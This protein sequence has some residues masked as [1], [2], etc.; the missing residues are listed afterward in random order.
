MS[1][2]INSSSAIYESAQVPKK[3][4]T[5][6]SWFLIAGVI[7][8]GVLFSLA[9]CLLMRWQETTHL[10]EGFKI[11]S[12]DRIKSIASHFETSGTFVQ[13]IAIYMRISEDVSPD[14]FR[15]ISASILAEHAVIQA[16]GWNPRVPSGQIAAH[17]AETRVHNPDYEVRQL[18][19]DGTTEVIDPQSN[20]LPATRILFAVKMIEPLEPNRSALGLDIASEPVRRDAIDRACRSGQPIASG[21]ITLVQE[22][23][24]QFGTLLITPVYRNTLPEAENENDERDVAGLVVGVFRIGVA[25]DTAMSNFEP[26]GIDV[27]LFDKSATPEKQFLHLHASRLRADLATKPEANLDLTTVESQLNE[28]LDFEF[29]G[30]Q[31]VLVCT[32]SDTYFQSG[33]TSFPLIVLGGG[34]V[35]TFLIVAY[36]FM[37]NQLT[38]RLRHELQARAEA[39]QQIA[40]QQRSLEHISRLTTMGEMVAGI[41]H[42]I[43][44]PLS[45]ISNF[46]AAAHNVLKKGGHDCPEPIDDWLRQIGTQTIR[47]GDIIRRLRSYVTKDTQEFTR[48][49]VNEIVRDSLALMAHDRHYPAGGIA[50]HMANPAPHVHASEVQLQQ[51]LVNLLRN[52]CDATQET[53]VPEIAVSV[54]RNDAR[55][56][57]T[58]KDNGPGI[59]PQLQAN[60]FEAFFTT[61]S[62]GLGMGLAI[63]KS[64]IEA[65]EGTL[66]YDS[67]VARGSE[68]HVELPVQHDADAI[69]IQDAKSM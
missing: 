35:V 47:C 36:I 8:C 67:E 45:A 30:R 3:S 14:Q 22:T 60:L 41:A 11:R 4:G 12:T 40:E 13:S 44:Q 9:L 27:R 51:V 21:R 1:D 29:G 15:A 62:D 5:A 37:Q 55:V 42:E 17:V 10:K 65:H 46:S 50:R 69:R 6:R 7:L 68:F 59:P 31:W 33:R 63:S 43:N 23:E 20:Q 54:T 38:E 19:S 18:R 49:N 64:I 58:V 66:W 61:K 16:I 2:S 34:L 32:P 26:A 52:A 24:S 25:I 48:V 56:H 53:E 28:S 57:I 39:E